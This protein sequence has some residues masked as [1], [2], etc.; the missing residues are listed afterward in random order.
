MASE[1]L[2]ES[3]YNPNSPV[4]HDAAINDSKDDLELVKDDHGQRSRVIEF[5]LGNTF[6]DKEHF[7]DAI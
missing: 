7:Y 5:A 3:L 1:T 6:Y 4:R 2:F